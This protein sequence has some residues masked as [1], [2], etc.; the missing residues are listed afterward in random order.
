MKWHTTS[1]ERGHYRKIQHYANWHRKFAWMPT[2][3]SDT[4]GICEWIWLV[5]VMRKFRLSSRK[6]NTFTFVGPIYTLPQDH[7]VDVLEDSKGDIDLMVFEDY[8]SK[9]RYKDLI[10]NLNIEDKAFHI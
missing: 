5:H 2:A 9:S 4:N 8:A 1:K 3:I 10:V 6:F 7:T